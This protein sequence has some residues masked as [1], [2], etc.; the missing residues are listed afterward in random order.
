[1]TDGLASTVTSTEPFGFMLGRAS[2]A[3]YDHQFPETAARQ[4]FDELVRH[5]TAAA[6]CVA[7]T[8]ASPANS[9]G[10]AAVT[11]AIRDQVVALVEPSLPEYGQSPKPC[12]EK[13][14]LLGNC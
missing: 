9:R 12:T 13:A 6:S 7:V 5:Q 14:G 4:V 10:V 11:P 8:E 1:M 2:C 3:G